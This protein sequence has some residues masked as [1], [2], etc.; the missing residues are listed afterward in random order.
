MIPF[1]ACAEGTGSFRP[2]Y[3]FATGRFAPGKWVDLP[4][5]IASYIGDYGTYFGYMLEWLMLEFSY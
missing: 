4:H 5:L 3:L 2:D 1:V